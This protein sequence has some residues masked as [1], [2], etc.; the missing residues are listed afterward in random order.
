LPRQGSEQASSEFQA[1]DAAFVRARWVPK[2]KVEWTYEANE[3]LLKHGAVKGRG[4]YDKRH[5][6]RWR[7]QR[8]I[9]LMVELGLHERW[10]L[11]E[12]TEARAGGGWTWSV[13]YLGGSH[14]S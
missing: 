14:G 10:E 4:V 5:V 13:E 12:H 11:K 1:P 2:H 7:A 3:I 6:A 9:R 8:L